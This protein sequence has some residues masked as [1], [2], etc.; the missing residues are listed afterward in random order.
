M[1]S[2]RNRVLSHYIALVTVFSAPVYGRI[3][4]P[5]AFVIEVPA[6]A[7]RF[8]ANLTQQPPT[9][10]RPVLAV[11][12]ALLAHHNRAFVAQDTAAWAQVS[13]TGFTRFRT[14]CTHW[15]VARV[16][17]GIDRIAPH[18]VAFHRVSGFHHFRHFCHWFR[19][20]H[21]DSLGDHFAFVVWLGA[22]DYRS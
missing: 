5:K 4:A 1:A 17:R 14:S 15:F 20:L 3:K 2:I 19:T 8:V 9:L 12:D 11:A 7:L 22:Q 10:L 13:A 18:A 6:R 16:A 21:L